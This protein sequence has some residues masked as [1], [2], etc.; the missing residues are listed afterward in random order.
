MNNSLIS[1]NGYFIENTL[2]VDRSDTHNGIGGGLLVY[3]KQEIT[4]LPI[5]NPQ[6]FNQYCKFLV[7]PAKDKTPLE[8][9][10]IY[11]SLNSNAENND[12]LCNLIKSTG[13]NSLLIGDFNYPN[14]EWTTM[15]G[16]NK[17]SN[18][19]QTIN[20]MFLSQLINFPTHIRGNILDLVFCSNP[21]NI[22]SMEC[23]G[24]LSNSDHAI[25]SLQI[26]FNAN[27]NKTAECI[28]D[29]SKANIDLFTDSLQ[30]IDWDSELS[31]KD[32]EAAWIF[33]KDTLLAGIDKFV[34]KK[35]RR[36]NNRPPWMTRE[37]IR[38]SRLKQRR[39]NTYKDNRSDHNFNNFKSAEKSAKQAVRKAKRKFEKK[40]ASNGNKRPF[41]AYLK[42]KT[43]SRTCIGPLKTGDAL[44]SDDGEMA[45]ILNNSFA[46]SF[47]LE[48]N[49]SLPNLNKLDSLTTLDN[50]VFTASLV[51]R[52]IDKLNDSFS[53]GPDQISNKLLK[54]F[55]NILSGP[56]ATLFNKSMQSGILPKDWKLGHITPIFKKGAKGDPGNYRPIS[57]TCVA[58]KLMES[59]VKDSILEHLMDNNLI[60][61]TQHGFMNQK[62]C[63]T[64]LLEFF[65]TITT[66]FD[67]GTPT[68][69][70][71]LDFSKA[72]DKVPK[73]R[74]LLKLREHSIESNVHTWIRDWLT[75]RKQRVV[76]N[77]KFSFWEEVVSGVIQGSVLGPV[78][79]IIYINDLDFRATLIS[80]IR[81]FADDTKL[82]QKITSDND[83]KLLQ[84]CLNNLCNWADTWGMEFNVKKCK[85]MHVGRT[86][87]N[88]DYFMNGEKL[89]ETLLERDIGVLIDKS[90][91][92]SNQCITA[93]RVANA[94]LGQICQAFHFRDRNIF[95][96]LYK[97]YVRVHLEFCTPAWSPWTAGDVELLEQ[98]QKRAVRN[99]S[100]LKGNTYEEK[101]Q[102]LGLT[103]LKDRR[104]RTDLIQT[105]KILKGFDNVNSNTWFSFVEPTHSRMTRHT[106]NPLNIQLKQARTEIRKNF[107]S[108]RIPEKWNSLPSEV[109][110][111]KTIHMFKSRYDS[112][113]KGTAS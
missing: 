89:T 13:D 60:N 85:I 28:P 94:V 81:K 58:C 7:I 70:I 102:E 5:D 55:S 32:T 84:D 20:D 25:I 113:F 41:N 75:D 17:S 35:H 59:I 78:A 10:L 63:V 24:N 15:M 88:F 111:S 103:T 6:I 42:S 110:E 112:W 56:L 12:N 96:K 66:Y 91:K 44:T 107:F 76:L 37:V 18:F 16:D 73:E 61:P 109:R 105:F 14:I 90:L 54:T 86:N 8:I 108:V 65:E 71:Y 46:N 1:I 29:W 21:D 83:R 95:L 100:G 3:V 77:G 69:I 39:W 52:K 2:R 38:L 82:G 27:I 51:K 30:S 67:S 92:P 93:A 49:N 97:Q 9:T 87:P 80:I 98:V 47:T 106:S 62:S 34:P 57:L 4:V 99:I 64:N 26:L 50:I 22:V 40:L 36:Q 11:K 74:L 19:L 104:L 72:F 53:A 31:N 48:N 68:D 101:L 79:F 43:K 23:L 33:F 45:N